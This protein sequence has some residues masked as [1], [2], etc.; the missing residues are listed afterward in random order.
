MRAPRELFLSTQCDELMQKELRGILVNVGVPVHPDE[1]ETSLRQK[2]RQTLKWL[3]ESGM[4]FTRSEQ[5]KNLSDTS[6]YVYYTIDTP[7]QS[8]RNRITIL[9]T[10]LDG[11]AIVVVAS[12][13]RSTDGS[14]VPPTVSQHEGMAEATA[15]KTANMTIKLAPSEN[16]DL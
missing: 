16:T 10:L 15:G 4:T 13:H 3:T 12:P 7:I 14:S 5:S 1:G 11:N 2:F 6:Q 9:G 8:E